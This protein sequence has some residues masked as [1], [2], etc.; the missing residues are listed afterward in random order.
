MTPDLG[1]KLL[2]AMKRIRHVEETIAARYAEQ[3]MRCPTHLS[4]GQEAVATAVGAVLRRDDLAVSGHRAHAHYL[5]KGGSL[6]A[7]IAEIYGKATG[8]AGGIGGSMH[9]V[10]EAAGFMGST[11]IVAGTVPVG[12]GLAYAIKLKR[13]DQVSCIFMGDAVAEAGVFFESINLAVLKQLPVLFIC[14]NN[15]YSVYSPLG[16]RQPE[17]RAIHKMV[18]AMGLPSACGDGNDALG[19]HQMVDEGARAIRAGGG[20][21][22]YEFMTYRWRE[23]CGPLYDNDLGYRRQ[24]EFAQ[25]KAKEPIA[26][27]ERKL[28][29]EGTLSSA[30]IA[31]MEREIGEEVEQA[32]AFAESSPWPEPNAAYAHVYASQSA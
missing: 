31:A 24:A 28:L 30:D 26:P 18:G 7:M 1:R 2:H 4:T 9:L 10:D 29:G 19:V 20:P 5:A 32:F 21:R 13:T 14:E 6:P 15:L 12:V 27:L 25:W 23:H 8:C 22:F 17:G 3:K 16:V 11:A